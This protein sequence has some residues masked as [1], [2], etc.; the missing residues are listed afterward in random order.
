MWIGGEAPV[1]RGAMRRRFD[2]SLAKGHD[3]AAT[4]LAESGEAR[5]GHLGIEIQRGVAAFG[6]LVARD[7]R[8]RG[9]G[10]AL[11]KAAVQWATEMGRRSGELWDAIMMAV[12]LENTSPG[13]PF[14]PDSTA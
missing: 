14:R 6:M 1:D 7:W 10:S 9:V 8:G 12:I 5:V 3:K 4:F 2:E 13:S 11:L